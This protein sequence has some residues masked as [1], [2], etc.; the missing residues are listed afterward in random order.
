MEGAWNGLEQKPGTQKKGS[1]SSTCGIHFLH[2]KLLRYD[3]KKVMYRGVY[4]NTRKK[5]EKGRRMFPLYMLEKFWR[6]FK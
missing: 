2:G 4:H 3:V 5:D 1:N 6:G